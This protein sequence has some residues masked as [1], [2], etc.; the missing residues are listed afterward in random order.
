MNISQSQ[1]WQKA[2][3]SI[4]QQVA[5]LL[6]WWSSRQVNCYISVFNLGIILK[7]F[8]QVFFFQMRKF[9]PYQMNFF[10]AFQPCQV[11]NDKEFVCLAPDLTDKDKSHSIGNGNS[12]PSFN[13]DQCRWKLRYHQ[14]DND[15]QLE[16][17]QVLHINALLIISIRK[18]II[19]YLS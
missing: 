19:F 9:H 17:A 10:F 18:A 8:P 16:F 11:L 14:F 5:L 13:R 12:Q 15:L 6:T 4:A 2:Q 7:I 1:K 3:F